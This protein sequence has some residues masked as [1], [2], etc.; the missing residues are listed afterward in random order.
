MPNNNRDSAIIL[1]DCPDQKGIVYKVCDFVLTNNGNIIKLDQH[2][3]HDDNRFFMRIEWDLEGFTIPAD[4]I[5]EY[6]QTLI[7][8]QYQMH[9]SLH[10]RNQKPKMAIL[11]SKYA[12]CIHDIL[13]RYESGEWDIEIPIIISNHEKFRSL[14]KQ[15]DIPFHYFPITKE[16]KLEQEKKEIALLREHKIDFVILARYMQILSSLLIEAF[17]MKVI[18]IHHSSLPAFAGANPY[19][20]AYLRGVKF[21][22]ATAH[23]VTE[24]LD[25]GPI[26]TQDVIPITH[27]DSISDMKRKGKNIEKIVFANAIWSH[28]NHNVLIYKNKTVVFE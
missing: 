5:K 28:L 19:K 15:H 23:Y 6:F 12:H 18:N 3:D 22:G 4:K 24:D 10:F 1:I 17:P 20:A 8:Q 7:A 14:A 11:V 13:S 25:E 21:M 16:N 27:R 26:I 9:W 2:V